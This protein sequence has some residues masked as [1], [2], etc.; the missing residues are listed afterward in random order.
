MLLMPSEGLTI[1]RL[2]TTGAGC[3]WNGQGGN[4][5]GIVMGLGQ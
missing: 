5:V 4:V 3:L 2:V 1:Y